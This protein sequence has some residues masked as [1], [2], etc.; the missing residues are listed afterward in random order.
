MFASG[1]T[2]SGLHEVTL[3]MLLNSI[4]YAMDIK[5][6]CQTPLFLQPAW[7]GLFRLT[8]SDR[9][10]WAQIGS[11]IF[12]VLIEAAM[13]LYPSSIRRLACIEQLIPNGQFAPEV[14]AAVRR[15]G[16]RCRVFDK[17]H[18]P[19]FWAGVQI[20]AQT[21]PTGAIRSGIR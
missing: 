10:P 1:C 19:S 5:S 4:H 11:R 6:A 7:T 8:A 21:K 17:G 16:Q 13:R 9:K 2:G 12:E 18:S 14:I 3:Q 20:E 15:K